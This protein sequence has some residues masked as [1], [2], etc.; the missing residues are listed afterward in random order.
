MNKLI[1]LSACLLAG[2]SKGYFAPV[3][4]ENI[5]GHAYLYYMNGGIIHAE[6]CQCKGAL[7]LMPTAN[8]EPTEPSTVIFTHN[9]APTNRPTAPSGIRIQP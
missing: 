2:C 6:H 8:V 9:I 5:K 4:E 7:I 1:L 3:K